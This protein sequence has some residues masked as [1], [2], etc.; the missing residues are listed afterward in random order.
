MFTVTIDISKEIIAIS[1]KIII[2]KS[3]SYVYGK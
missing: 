3:A 2:I 1:N